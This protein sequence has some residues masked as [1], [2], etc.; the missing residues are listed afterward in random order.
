M[1]VHDRVLAGL[2]D[3]GNTGDHGR[4]RPSTRWRRP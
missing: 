1:H 3:D 4:E 2:A